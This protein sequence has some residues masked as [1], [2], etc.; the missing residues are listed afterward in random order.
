MASI[1]IQT[2]PKD[3]PLMCQMLA[4]LLGEMEIVLR[5]EKNEN[6]LNE[7]NNLY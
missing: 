2:T 6:F 4:M 5:G 1:C 7:Y 3:C